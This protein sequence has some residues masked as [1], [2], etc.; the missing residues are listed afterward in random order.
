MIFAYILLMGI[1]FLLFGV[2]YSQ[3]IVENSRTFVIDNE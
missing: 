2:I 1:L 3:S